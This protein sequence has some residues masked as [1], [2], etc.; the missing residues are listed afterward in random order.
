MCYWIVFGPLDL[1]NP[2]SLHLAI[3]LVAGSWTG[4]WKCSRPGDASSVSI[5]TLQRS[6][7]SPSTKE[8]QNEAFLPNGPAQTDREDAGIGRFWEGR[9]SGSPTDAVAFQNRRPFPLFTSQRWCAALVPAPPVASS[10]SAPERCDCLGLFIPSFFF[11]FSFYWSVNSRYHRNVLVHWFLHI[12][13]E[14]SFV[15]CSYLFEVN[16]LLSYP[17][18]GQRIREYMSSQNLFVLVAQTYIGYCV[19]GDTKH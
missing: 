18:W 11:S 2:V 8:K 12:M 9:R 10:P 1:T 4:N 5:L 14:S 15:W 19:L 13:F 16:W 17:N 6:S 7:R 3:A